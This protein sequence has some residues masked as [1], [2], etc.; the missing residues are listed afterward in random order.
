MKID[1]NVE[2]SQAID[3]PFFQVAAV[4]IYLL[5]VGSWLLLARRIPGPGFRRIF[6]ASFTRSYVGVLQNFVPEQGHC[7]TVAVPEHLLSDRESASRLRLFEN[8]RPVGAPHSLHDEIRRLG[9][10]RF[11]HWGPTLYFSTPDNTDP[12]MNGRRYVVREMP[13]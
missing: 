2:R 5:L 3:T 12:R 8:E 13:E 10:G 7:Y 11:S 1:G 9:E 6:A 4:S